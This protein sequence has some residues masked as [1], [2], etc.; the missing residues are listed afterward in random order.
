MAIL[1]TNVEN[2]GLLKIRCKYIGTHFPH[3]VIIAGGIYIH[4][5]YNQTKKNGNLDNLK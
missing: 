3:I 5:V 1:C 2:N 4:Q